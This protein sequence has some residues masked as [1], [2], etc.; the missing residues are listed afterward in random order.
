MNEV[1]G[2]K[3]KEVKWNWK[4]WKFFGEEVKFFKWNGMKYSEM[5]Q[6][7]MKWYSLKLWDFIFFC[8]MKKFHHG[9]V[10]RLLTLHF[11]N[12]GQP[13][14]WGS[15]QQWQGAIRVWVRVQRVARPYSSRKTGWKRHAKA[16][17]AGHQ[18]CCSYIFL[19]WTS[20][21]DQKLSPSDK[22]PLSLELGLREEMR[23]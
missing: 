7:F 22:M 10:L 12:L 23:L 18:F 11:W 4:K 1:K 16:I 8:E 14:W 21:D 20:H 13:W 5:N 6:N 2:R 9:R 3:Y 19:I 17:L 15:Q